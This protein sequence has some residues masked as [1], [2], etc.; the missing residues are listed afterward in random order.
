MAEALAEIG[1]IDFARGE[2]ANGQTEMAQVSDR[3]GCTLGCNYKILLAVV[4]PPDVG[5]CEQ[6]GT[7]PIRV[8]ELPR[9]AVDVCVIR[10]SVAIEVMKCLLHRVKWIGCT[11][12]EAELDQVSKIVRHL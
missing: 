3:F 4:W 1:T 12:E 2:F 6:T 5:H 11:G 8:G 10:N 7:K 9:G